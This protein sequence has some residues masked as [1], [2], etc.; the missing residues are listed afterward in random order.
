[1][2]HTHLRTDE[3]TTL[4]EELLQLSAETGVKGAVLF[5]GILLSYFVI[6][7]L[8]TTVTGSYTPYPFFSLEAD[9][10]LAIDS[11]IVGILT[12]QG[13]G[14]LLLYHFYVGISDDSRLSVL[15]SFIGLGIGGALLQMSLPETWGLLVSLV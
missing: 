3:S 5:G 7:V 14:S 1:M 11:T 4:I 13:S 9:P 2:F 10:V 6:G 12:V 8:A 15:L